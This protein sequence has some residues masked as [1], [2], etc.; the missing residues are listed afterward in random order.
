MTNKKSGMNLKQSINLAFFMAALLAPVVGL[1]KSKLNLENVSPTIWVFIAFYILLRIK[2]F[3]DDHG[4]FGSAES[5]NPHFRLGFILAIFSWAVWCYSGYIVATQQGAFFGLG[6]AIAISTLWIVIVAIRSGAYKEQYYWLAT[7][8][9]YIIIL[10]IAYKL[11][12]PETPYGS[13][14]IWI[15]LGIGVCL[16]ALD[17]FLSE[18]FKHIEQ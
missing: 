4:Y 7:N 5:A 1:A 9:I 11:Y 13:W 8:V 17:Y 6:V 12:A 14:G 10:W 15:T 16:V 18:S 3:L 2:T